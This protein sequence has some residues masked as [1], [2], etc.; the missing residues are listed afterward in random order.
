LV[1]TSD[2]STLKPKIII[3]KFKIEIKIKKGVSEIAVAMVTKV[4][5]G[6]LGRL[7]DKATP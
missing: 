6:Y 2:T 7:Y 1:F 4:I 5:L 3:K